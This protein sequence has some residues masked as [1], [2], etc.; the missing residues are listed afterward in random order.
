MNKYSINSAFGAVL[1]FMFLVLA[2]VLV[3]K[4]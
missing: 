4:L 1:I 2:C 3:G